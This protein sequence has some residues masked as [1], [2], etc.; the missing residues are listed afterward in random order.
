MDATLKEYIGGCHCE[1]FRY[2]FIHPEF[3]AGQFEVV[4]CNCSIC[5]MKGLLNV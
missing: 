4:S 5:A 2:K 3:E 1:R